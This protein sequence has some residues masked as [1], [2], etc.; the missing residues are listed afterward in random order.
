M[1]HYLDIL[2]ADEHDEKR[3]ADL[4]RN[5]EAMQAEDHPAVAVQAPAAV[6]SEEEV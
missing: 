6:K 3:T 4:A 2:L 1:S 5:D